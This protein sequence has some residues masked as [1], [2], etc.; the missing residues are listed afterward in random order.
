[1]GPGHRCQGI[2][3][4]VE[5][6]LKSCAGPC[7]AYVP[8]QEELGVLKT[9]KIKAEPMQRKSKRRK[10]EQEQKNKETADCWREDVA[11]TSHRNVTAS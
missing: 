6:G 1:M 2:F 3:C 5:V 7:E 4:W 10:E 11:E 8:V 9:V